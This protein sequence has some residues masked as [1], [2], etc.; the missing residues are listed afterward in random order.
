M[1]KEKR[2]IHLIN[3][4][5]KARAG[6][7]MNGDASQLIGL[8]RSLESWEMIRKKAIKEKDKR[9]R[10]QRVIKATFFLVP[11]GHGPNQDVEMNE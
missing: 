8:T 9:E 3:S 5:A 6:T 7:M 11:H 1:T 10:K 4:P 2:P